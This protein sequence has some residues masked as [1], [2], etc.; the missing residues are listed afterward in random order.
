MKIILF[1]DRL[2]PMI[3]GMET[4]A[5]YFVQFF[6]KTNELIIISRNNGKDVIVDEKYNIIKE[7]NLFEFLKKF[8]NEKIVVF[9]NSGRW[10]ENF[11]NI[12]KLLPLAIIIYRTGGNEIIQAPLD[13]N[14][15]D[16]NERKLYWRNSINQ[17]I[18]WLITNSDFTSNRLIEF[19][20]NKKILIKIGGGIDEQV[21]K[22]A[23]ANKT[24]TRRNLQINKEENV[25][26][27]CARFVPYKRVDFLIK[28]LDLCNQKLILLLA[29]DGPLEA[30]LK[31]V[32]KQV[33]YEIK[34]LGSL[35]Q[36]EAVELIAAGDVYVQASTDLERIVK[37]GSYIHTEGMGRSLLE[38][39][40]V[41]VP[42]VMTKCGAVGEYINSDNG[43]LVENMEDFAMCV[44]DFLDN[45]NKKNI[46]NHNDIKKYSF[47]KLFGEYKK[48]WM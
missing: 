40:C 26:V 48:L 18:D 22:D 31:T 30:M 36:K 28:A 7:I 17:S 25:C 46:N 11:I 6:N 47:N 2:P 3:G 38:A 15:D 41:G 21:V 4:H 13:L 16:Y 32:A 29:G 33:S 27:C 35:S 44:D 9:Y 24:N 12:R 34:F 42:I 10:I 19:G 37:G 45:K 1:A 14:I 39:I 8:S 43:V 20:I 5:H 23:I